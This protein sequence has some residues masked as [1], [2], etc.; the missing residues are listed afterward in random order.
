MTPTKRIMRELGTI[1]AA[2][3]RTASAAEGH[4][5]QVDVLWCGHNRQGA[6]NRWSFPPRVA[7]LLREEFAGKRICHLFGGFSK[8][9]TRLDI[10][11]ATR[12]HVLGDAWLPPFVKDAFDVVVLDPP[13]IGINQQMKQQLL[14]GASWIAR[15]HVVW[16]HTQWIAAGT[17]SCVFERGWLVRVGDSCAVRCIQVF[18]TSATKTN[19]TPYFTRGP[20]MRY[21]R[22]LAGQ[23]GLPY[24]APEASALPRG[25]SQTSERSET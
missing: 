11:T 5:R 22:W 2:S 12:P 15:E 21:N 19:R 18:R 16:F 13:Y 3:S 6:S 23:T 4:P 8:F 24:G 25:T 9:G 14:R 7:R 10:D 17:T 1:D 20:A